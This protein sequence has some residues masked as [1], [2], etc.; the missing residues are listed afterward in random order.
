MYPELSYNE[1]VTIFNPTSDNYG[2]DVLGNGTALKCVFEQTTGFQHGGHQD[3]IVGVSRI[4]LDP[5][6]NFVI[7][8]GY[9]LEGMIVKINPFGA[10]AASQYFRIISVTAGRDVLQNNKVRHV[11]C[12]LSKTNDF[13]N[14]A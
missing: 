7:D 12:E 9:R 3:S 2:K 1:T 8:N 6:S 11:E 10:D 5:N 14:E 13:D 4:Y